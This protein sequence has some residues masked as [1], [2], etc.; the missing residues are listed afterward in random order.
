MSYPQFRSQLD[1]I[2][3]SKNP[4]AVR[5]FLVEQGQWDEGFAG[6]VEHAMWMMIAGSPGLQE[7]HPEALDWLTQHG[8]QEEAAVLRERRQALRKTPPTPARAKGGAR[9]EKPGSGSRHLRGRMPRQPGTK[10]TPGQTPR[11]PSRPPKQP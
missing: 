11:Q 8:Y 2:L 6:D 3:R 10:S 9:A 1:S 4:E 5:R 7:L